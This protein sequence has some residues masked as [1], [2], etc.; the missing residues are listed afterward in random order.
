M[1]LSSNPSGCNCPNDCGD[2][3]DAQLIVLFRL[4]EPQ[5]FEPKIGSHRIWDDYGLVTTCVGERLYVFSTN[6]TK[7]FLKQETISAPVIVALLYAFELSRFAE[8]SRRV[9]RIRPYELVLDGLQYRE[10][11]PHTV[12]TEIGAGR[13]LS[14]AAPDRPEN[15]L[16]NPRHSCSDLERG[17]RFSAA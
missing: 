16:G 10:S 12:A 2:F 14:L 7:R 1:L 5:G 3:Y 17:S 6:E 11:P 4:T 15:K 8:T 13:T 9:G